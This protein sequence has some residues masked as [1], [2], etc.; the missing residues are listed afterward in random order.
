[1]VY[2]YLD[3]RVP[4]KQGCGCVCLTLSGAAHADKSEE[5]ANLSASLDLTA[6][7]WFSG[8]EAQDISAFCKG[9][10]IFNLLSHF[11]LDAKVSKNQGCGSV[12]STLPG[13]AHADKS[14]EVAACQCR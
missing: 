14:E 9:R 12:H 11:S 2:F 13:A 4:K 7:S 3:A 6:F 5:V 8:R 1:M 10:F